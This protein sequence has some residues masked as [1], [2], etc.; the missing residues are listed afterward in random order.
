M[1]D[2]LELG[3]L[4]QMG[5]EG[6]P[7][8]Q[9]QPMDTQRFGNNYYYSARRWAAGAL[10]PPGD[11][12][13]FVDPIGRAGQGFVGI[14]EWVTNLGA[15]GG[16]VPAGQAWTIAEVG[17]VPCVENDYR[18]NLRAQS[19]MTLYLEKNS[20]R[21]NMGPILLWPGGAGLTG[22]GVAD[23]NPLTTTIPALSNGVPAHGARVKLRVPIKLQAKE[24]FK[25]GFRVSP[26]LAFT[27]NADYIHHLVLF[28]EFIEAVPA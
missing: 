6:G 18:D 1:D 28:G 10:V 22:A 14:D 12:D 23:T 11:Y 17:V 25:F 9:D 8:V 20:M 13:V 2:I 27:P 3:A 19:I 16:E 26:R 24:V 4:V 21:R 5:G 15:G 7:R